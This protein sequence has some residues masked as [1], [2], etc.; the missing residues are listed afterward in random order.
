[1]AFGFTSSDAESEQAMIHAEN[2][3]AAIRSTMQPGLV[4]DYCHDCG[5]DIPVARQDFFK[6]RNQACLYCVNC[7]DKHFRLPKV[8][9]LDRIL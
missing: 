7:A 6:D 3:I 9:M 4:S 1:M 8:K 2:G 5:E